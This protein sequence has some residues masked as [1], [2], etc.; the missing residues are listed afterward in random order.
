[1]KEEK[2]DKK[3]IIRVSKVE[4]KRLKKNAETNNMNLSEY[5]IS[6]G[7]RKNNGNRD[8][9]ANMAV[10]VQEILNY[11]EERYKEDIELRKRVDNIWENL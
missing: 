11:I 3:I 8:Y 10:A 4:K 2:K 9:D 5:I 7:T 6:C 1:M